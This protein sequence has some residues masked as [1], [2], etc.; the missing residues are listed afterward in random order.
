MKSIS[1]NHQ[2]Y[3]LR[4]APASPSP[5]PN[6]YQGA[7]HRKPTCNPEMY[8]GVDC[9]APTTCRTVYRYGM[10]QTECGQAQPSQLSG[11]VIVTL[12]DDSYPIRPLLDVST[13]STMPPYVNKTQP[14]SDSHPDNTRCGDIA[15]CEEHKWS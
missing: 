8:P 7:R 12:Q 15:K 2:S 10:K 6:F 14:E 5:M 13:T 11:G 9:L 4:E 1:A 3:I